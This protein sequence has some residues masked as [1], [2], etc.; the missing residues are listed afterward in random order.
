MANNY[1]LVVSI[2]LK[3]SPWEGLHPIDEMENKIHV[4]N[5]QPDEILLKQTSLIY[6]VTLFST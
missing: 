5:H 2:P 4:W 6:D 1:W 3:H